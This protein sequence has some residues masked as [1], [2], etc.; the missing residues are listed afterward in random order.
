MTLLHTVQ[1]WHA[2]HDMMGI[3]AC[4]VWLYRCGDAVSNAE[5][6]LV[7]RPHNPDSDALEQSLLRTAADNF[8]G[9]ARWCIRTTSRLPRDAAPDPCTWLPQLTA[10]LRHQSTCTSGSTELTHLMY[11]IALADM[12]LLTCS[13][14]TLASHAVQ[15][16]A[17]WRVREHLLGQAA[18]RN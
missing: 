2:D 14:D 17:Y 18:A 4:A 15:I 11:Q 1:R 16:R 8:D 6:S 7:M 5:L 12:T 10:S 9:L 3:C 13:S